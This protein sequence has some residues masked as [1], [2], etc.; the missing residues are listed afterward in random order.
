[1]KIAI[2]GSGYVGLVSAACLADVGHRVMCV[3]LDQERVDAL[4]AGHVP[5]YEPGL[6]ELL[7]SNIDAGQLFFSTD[8]AEAVRFADLLVVAVGTPQLED[9]S[10]DISAVLAVARTIGE[11]ID[12][13]KV[14]VGKS[15][16]PVEPPTE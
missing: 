6:T 13:Y 7:R 16:V 5:I 12:G 14:V 1:M 4:S 10:A 2:F 11:N 3:D 15:T 9:G 8:G